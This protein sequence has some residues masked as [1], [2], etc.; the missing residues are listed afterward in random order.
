MG[1][2]LGA[3]SY[4]IKPVDRERLVALI[5]KHRNESAK[6]KTMKLPVSLSFSERHE[7]GAADIVRRR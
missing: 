5:Q 2:N 7:Q 6:P 4:V 3:S 1:T